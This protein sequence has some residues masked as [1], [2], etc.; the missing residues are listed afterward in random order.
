MKRPKAKKCTPTTIATQATMYSLAPATARLASPAAIATTSAATTSRYW[1]DLNIEVDG[2]GAVRRRRTAR[3]MMITP[4]TMP[5]AATG[6]WAAAGSPEAPHSAQA[7]PNAAVM[8]DAVSTPR[9]Q[10]AWPWT[11]TTPHSPAVR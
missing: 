8:M 6:P 9:C 11:D 1:R 3:L 2:A 4:A 10:T 5:G 7:M